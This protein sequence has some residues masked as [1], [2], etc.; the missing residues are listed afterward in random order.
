MNK[1]VTMAMGAV[2]LAAAAQGRVPDMGRSDYDGRRG[3]IVQEI[4]SEV[5]NRCMGELYEVTRK[6]KRRAG[7]DGNPEHTEAGAEGQSRPGPFSPW[8]IDE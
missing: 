8:S 3:R 4:Y 6:M 5:D 1:Y 7:Q 2:M